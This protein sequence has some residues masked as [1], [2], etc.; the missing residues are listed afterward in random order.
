MFITL[1]STYDEQT[2]EY[3]YTVDKTNQEIYDAA[4]GGKNVRMVYYDED[5]LRVF[6]IS[7]CQAS[8]SDAY[9]AYMRTEEPNSGSTVPASCM[10]VRVYMLA[11]DQYVKV[12]VT[13]WQVTLDD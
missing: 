7:L 13:S 11:D 3:T 10:S 6:T 4:V 9:F 8:I 12:A 5:T 2:E 1:S